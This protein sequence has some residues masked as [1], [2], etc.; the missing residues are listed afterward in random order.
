ME[1]RDKNKKRSGKEGQPNGEAT[2]LQS[3]N[4]VATSLGEHR[5]RPIPTRRE[6]RR[7]QRQKHKRKRREGKKQRSPTIGKP[8]PLPAKEKKKKQKPQNQKLNNYWENRPQKTQKKKDK[9]K[10]MHTFGESQACAS[11]SLSNSR[12][13]KK[14]NHIR[15]HSEDCNSY[16]N[17]FHQTETKTKKRD[18]HRKKMVNQTHRISAKLPESN[19]FERSKTRLPCFANGQIGR[20]LQRFANLKA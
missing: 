2:R 13:C 7:W 3:G 19:I 15:Q 12:P 10:K 8:T 4:S 18:P 14:C 9:Q 6:P 17:A 16:S 5:Q 11:M 20:N 1:T